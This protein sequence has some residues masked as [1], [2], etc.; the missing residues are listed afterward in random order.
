MLKADKMSMAHSLESR[1]PFLDRNVFELS[2]TLPVEQRL[3]GTTTKYALRTAAHEVLPDKVANK[4]KLGFPVPMRVW[5][6]EDEYYTKAREVFESS[7]AEQ[8]FN[9]DELVELLDQHREGKQDNSRKIWTV[10]VF[11]I[12]Y[13]VFFEDKLAEEDIPTPVKLADRKE[14]VA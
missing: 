2:R 12:W 5:L 6:K 7:E 13:G 14:H 9:T 3:N 1:V 10:Y 8:F 11:L 4:K